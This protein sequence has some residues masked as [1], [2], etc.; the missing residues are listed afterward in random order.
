MDFV[1]IWYDYRCLSKILFGTTH[2][3]AYDLEVKVALGNLC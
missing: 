3:H 1:Y 2:I